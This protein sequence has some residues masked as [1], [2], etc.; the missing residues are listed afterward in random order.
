MDGNEP[1]LTLLN[2]WET[3]K[4]DF[5]EARLANLFNDAAKLGVALFLLD[6]GW[7]GNKYPRINDKQ[8]LGDW[9]PTKT[10]L[11]NGF[12]GLTHEGNTNGVKFGIWVE[13]EMINAK[14]ELYEKHPDW[15]LRLPNRPDSHIKNMRDQYIVDLVNPKVQDFVFNTIDNLFT[16]NPALAYIKWDCNTVLTNA[17]SPYLKSDQSTLFIEYTRCLYKVLDRIRHKYPHV[18]M[19]LCSGGGARADYGALKY[20]TEFWPSDN[21]YPVDRIYIQWGYSYFFP[22]LALCNHITSSGKESLKF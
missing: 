18:P 6:D 20:F 2:N 12:T 5:N 14:S 21:T 15:I 7:F 11:P 1:R 10:K 9:E 8:G 3:T 22:S 4:F 13:P 16:Q 17:W 19:M